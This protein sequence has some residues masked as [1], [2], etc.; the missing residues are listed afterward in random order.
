MTTAKISI[1]GN[2]YTVSA[3]NLKQIKDFRDDIK[4]LNEIAKGGFPENEQ[5]D[6]VIRL[7]HASLSKVHQGLTEEQVSE[8]IDLGNMAQ[9]IQMVMGAAGLV[10]SGQGDA[11]N[12]A[13]VQ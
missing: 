13:A 3:L 5:L 12:V 1:N 6:S 9:L 4:S 7:V 2:E 8:M 11:G 10:S